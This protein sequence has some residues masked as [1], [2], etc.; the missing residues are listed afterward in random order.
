MQIKRKDIRREPWSRVIKRTQVF[1]ATD[2]GKGAASLLRFDKLTEPFI[3]DYGDGKI[4]PVIFEGGYWLQYCKDGENYFYTAIFDESGTFRQVYIDITAGNVC[5]APDVAYFD[6]LFLDIVYTPDGKIYIF[7]RDELD[8]ALSDKTIDERTYE[9]V[10]ELAD[11][12]TAELK[13][14]GPDLISRFIQ[15]YK[16]LRAM[17]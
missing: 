5:T 3:K 8:E 4:I 16:T 9:R 13:T 12:K 15:L 6:D 2:G 7:D 10:L 14:D 17:M 1:S 11:I